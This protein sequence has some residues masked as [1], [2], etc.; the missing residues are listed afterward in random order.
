MK[1]MKTNKAKY[2]AISDKRGRKNKKRQRVAKAKYIY[3]KDTNKIWGSPFEKQSNVV[4][5]NPIPQS[6]T[7]P[8]LGILPSI[9]KGKKHK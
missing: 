6:S 2:R 9:F 7:S 8:L 3:E 5:Q 1:K 4:D